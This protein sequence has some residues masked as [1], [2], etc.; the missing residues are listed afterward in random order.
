MKGQILDFSV[1]TNSGVISGEDGMR[2]TFTGY[3]WRSEITPFQGMRVD[4]DTH[5]TDAIEIYKVFGNTSP[6][7]SGSKNKVAA[8]L[9][10][11]LGG[12]GIHKF[13]LGYTGPGLVFLLTNTI[14]WIITWLMLGLPNIVLGIISLIEGIIYL[15]K[16]D[17]E[18]EQ[19]YVIGQKQW[20]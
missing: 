1:Q 5:G 8:G 12:L 10:A 20:F 16:S 13:Y 4:F 6:G 19:T 17:E 2:Y 11:I 3:D 9:L 14:G 7:I 18:F 15:T